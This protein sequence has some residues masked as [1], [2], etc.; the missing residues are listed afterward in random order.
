MVLI[1]VANFAS[2]KTVVNFCVTLFDEGLKLWDFGGVG[3]T[4]AHKKPQ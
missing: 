1:T 4:V 3:M 2:I